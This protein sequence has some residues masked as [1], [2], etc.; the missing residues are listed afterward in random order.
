MPSGGWVPLLLLTPPHPQGFRQVATALPLPNVTRAHLP[1]GYAN[2]KPPLLHFGWSFDPDALLEWG[3]KN[4]IDTTEKCQEFDGPIIEEPDSIS[5]V[6]NQ[7]AMEILAK[8]A[9]TPELQPTFKMSVRANGNFLITISSNYSFLKD[10]KTI[11]QVR[12]DALDRYLKE[13]GIVQDSPGW[14]LDYEH[15]MWRR[16]Y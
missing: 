16:I 3:V 10:R 4:G 1:R 2:Y 15:Y 13:Q 14:H 11:P 9:G 5:T 6:T 8:K 7:E 12:I